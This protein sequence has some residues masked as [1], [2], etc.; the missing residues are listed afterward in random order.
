MIT[1]CYIIRHGLTVNAKEKR[2]TGHLDVNLSQEGEEQM[3]RLAF[4]LSTSANNSL[5]SVY[6]SD[7]I[8]AKRSAE[9]IGWAFGIKKP[10]IVPDFRE[11]SFGHWEGLTFDEIMQTYPEE[12]DAWAKS[13]LEFMPIGGESIMDVRSRVMPFFN[14][15]VAEN[16]G[17]KIAI[18]AHG[19]V[20]RI[21]LCELLGIPLQNIF[22]IGQD[23]GALNV[24]IFHDEVPVLK[25]MNYMVNPGQT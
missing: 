25:L 1:I 24:C 8:R 17:K 10:I 2:Y 3:E 9:I 19:G 5:D 15:I 16:R 20:N 11:C 12:F 21:I 7:L 6:C 4:H 13:P 23:F 18:V 14:N 22:K